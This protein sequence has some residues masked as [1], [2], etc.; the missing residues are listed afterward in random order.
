MRDDLEIGDDYQGLKA[1]INDLYV[2]LN[3]ISHSLPPYDIERYFSDIDKLLKQVNIKES[4][5]GT[6]QR[7]V[8]QFH[9][10]SKIRNKIPQQRNP[11]ATFIDEGKAVM[12][13]ATRVGEVI[14]L[15][16]P[17]AFYENLDHCTLNSTIQTIVHHTGS[18]TLQHINKTIVNLAAIPF[19]NGSIFITDCSDSIILCKTP[20]NSTVQIRLHNLLNCRLLI[21]S[22]DEH[23]SQTVILENCQKCIFHETCEPYLKVQDF[24]NLSLLNTDLKSTGGY[25]FE[26]F[27]ILGADSKA[28]KDKYIS[29]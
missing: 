4:T 10:H 29:S 13:P 20:P 26:D 9:K 5:Q 6:T 19:V 21:R 18:L 23:S 2:Y 7:K 12:T 24:S 25:R 17:T 28:L 3:G 15:S 1:K 22:T 27:D 8:F 14:N 11:E 16:E